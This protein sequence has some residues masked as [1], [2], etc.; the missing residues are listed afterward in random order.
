MYVDEVP[1]IL[2]HFAEMVARRSQR[3]SGGKYRWYC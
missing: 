3:C 2:D 1:M